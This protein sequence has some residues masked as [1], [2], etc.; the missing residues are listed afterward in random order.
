MTEFKNEIEIR[1]DNSALENFI[2]ELWKEELGYYDFSVTQLDTKG[3]S[4][5]TDVAYLKSVLKVVFFLN[6][7]SLI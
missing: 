2:N 5:F 7:I 4:F 6:N 1:E 3:I